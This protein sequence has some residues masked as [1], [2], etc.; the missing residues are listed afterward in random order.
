MHATYRN[1]ML[2]LC[3]G[4]LDKGGLNWKYRKAR[5]FRETRRDHDYN[6]APTCGRIS[7]VQPLVMSES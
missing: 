3:N 1:V 2:R 6:H 7:K 4:S 5:I